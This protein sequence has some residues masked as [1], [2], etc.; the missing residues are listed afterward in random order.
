MK[1][2]AG[3]NQGAGEVGEIF[4]VRPEDDRTPGHD[5]LDRILTAARGQAFAH[6][7]N[8]RGRV[9]I[10]QFPGGIEEQ[11]VRGYRAI[12]RNAPATRFEA[13]CAQTGG[14][15]WHPLDVTRR[16]QEKKIGKIAPQLEKNAAQDFL[17]SRVGAAGEQD[18]PTR[19]NA[20]GL[21]DGL[22]DLGVR[23]DV[24]GIVFDASDRINAL[25]SR[26]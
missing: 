11:A 2:A 12:G 15:L 22:R 23:R 10:A 13:K 3:R 17:L 26:A 5:R 14:N 20:K 19:I 1:G 4:H 18:R 6:E 25:R 8:R 21:E 24:F 7:N 16:N 9:P